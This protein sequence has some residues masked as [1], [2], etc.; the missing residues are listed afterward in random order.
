MA[1]L[2]TTQK[3]AILW[4]NSTG[5]EADDIAKELKIESSQV[6]NII[7]KLPQTETTE[8]KTKKT[9][10]KDLMITESAAG[11]YNVA[12]MTKSASEMNDEASK[13]NKTTAQQ[14]AKPYIY[15]PNNG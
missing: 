13:Q 14:L 15:R 2:N 9:T 6:K 5:L 3:Y 4:L 11:K 8:N 1:R 7:K 10:S 12:I